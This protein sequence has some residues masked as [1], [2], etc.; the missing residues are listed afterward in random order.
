ECSRPSGATASRSLSVN[1]TG[2]TTPA[3]CISSAENPPLC[4]VHAGTVIACTSSSRFL[5]SKHRIGV[6]SDVP[7]VPRRRH[8][9]E[10]GRAAHS[11]AIFE[12]PSL[13]LY[14]Q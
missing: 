1:D 4:G 6:W 9:Q 2:Q 5:G 8:T 13:P 14:L 7:A 11:A 3:T 10:R 12:D